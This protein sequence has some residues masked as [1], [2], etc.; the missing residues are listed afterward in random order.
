MKEN[1]NNSVDFDYFMG[2]KRENGRAGV[3]NYVLVIPSV[4]CAFGTS[5]MIQEE[6]PEVLIVDNQYGCSQIEIDTEQTM[7][8]LSGLAKN[9]NIAK[10]LVISLGCET[11]PSSELVE[12]IRK[13]KKDA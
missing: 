1:L 6:L 4:S 3:R 11:L 13:S 2:Y 8:I 12:M 10:V 9:P 7:V 5:R